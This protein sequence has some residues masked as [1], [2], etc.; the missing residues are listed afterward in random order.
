MPYG[1]VTATATL[2][3]PTSLQ[4]SFVGSASDISYPDVAS[5]DL[6]SFAG[7]ATN[8]FGLRFTGEP[9]LAR[10]HKRH[11]FTSHKHTR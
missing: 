2:P 1:S 5:S 8:H 4:P 7:G 10:L 3:I 11:W 6:F 9:L